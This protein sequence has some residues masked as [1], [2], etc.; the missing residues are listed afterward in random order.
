MKEAAE[1]LGERPAPD[2]PWE[3]TDFRLIFGRTGIDYDPEKEEE[4]RKK[5]GYS[6][7]SAVHF[8]EGMLLPLKRPLV[9][10]RGPIERGGE[11]RFEHMA[12]D[13]SGHVVLF[14]TTMRPGET[15]R[16]ISMRRASEKEEAVYCECLSALVRQ[17][18]EKD[19]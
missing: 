11:T 17:F 15:V 19:Q 3:A 13:T 9:L 12:V 4:N 14:V 5:H 2:G 18:K 6:L 16:V 8:F 7:E 10:T 1:T